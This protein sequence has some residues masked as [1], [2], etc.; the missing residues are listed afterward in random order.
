MKLKEYLQKLV[1]TKKEEIRNA[2][3]K[4]TDL[5]KQ[6]DASNNIDEV[7]RF[8]T[9]ARSL[10]ETLIKLKEELEDAQKQLDSIDEPDPNQNES[11][12]E[13]G[14]ARKLNPLNTLQM[15][16]GGSGKQPGS[17]NPRSTMEYRKAFMDYVQR[18]V[19]SPILEKRTADQIEHGDLGVLLPETVVQQVIKDVEQVYGQ[20]YSRVKKTNLKGGVKYP[21]G[22]FSATFKRIT[23]TTVS[24]RQS[25]GG[26]TG[27][28][29]FSY[30]IGECRIATSLLASILSVPVFEAE[31][32]KAI[33]EAYVKAM[34]TEILI[35]ND[36]SNEMVGILTEANKGG[37][38]RIPTANVITFTETEMKKWDTWNK[39]LFAKIP[40]SMR[41][42]RPTFF[43]TVNTFESNLKTLQDSNGNPI[44]R[45]VVNLVDGNETA[46]FNGREVV[47]LESLENAIED[48]DTAASGDYF[49][50]YMVPEKAYA[51]NSNLA[52][53]VVH[54]FDQ[55]TNQYVDKAIVIN[56]GK[57]LDGKYIYLLKKA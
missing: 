13:E 14:G 26:V 16:T 18:G 37:S 42:E 53:S 1:D 30:K 39:K 49:G 6:I 9:E 47:F 35:G 41:K 45:E 33:V 2:D 43:L 24:E 8:N 48:F 50:I 54:Y 36:A 25:T 57:V 10:G 56:D 23:E 38:G 11:G 32:S 4:R 52:F 7:K 34:D 51:I 40:I 19:E 28:V 21:L 46:R 15:R 31:I 29:E 27:Y 22:S 17:D 20:L 44:A 5:Q 3:Q 12:G 55:D